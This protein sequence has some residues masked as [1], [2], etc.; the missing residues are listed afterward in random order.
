MNDNRTTT[1]E[2]KQVSVEIR[3]ATGRHITLTNDGITTTRTED[4]VEP[5]TIL[6]NRPAFRGFVMALT[7]LM[8]WSLHRHGTAPAT[9]TSGRPRTTPTANSSFN[10]Q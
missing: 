4:G 1:K 9:S 7:E 8:G 3:T 2:P 6:Q 5:R 10:N